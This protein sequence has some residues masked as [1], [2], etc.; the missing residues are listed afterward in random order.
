MKIE[1]LNTSKQPQYEAFA[2]A[3]PGAL[4][5]HSL[6]FRDFLEE[7]LGCASHYLL[8]LEDNEILGVLPLMKTPGPLG[9]VW[10]SLPFY[11]SNGGLLA[12]SAEAAQSLIAAYNEVVSAPQVAS[13]TLISSPLCPDPHKGLRHNCTDTRTG[14][15]TVLS[16]EDH[17]EDFLL[18]R[19][20]SSARRNV[21]KA[22]AADI[23]V[24]VDNTAT[25][26]LASAHF[27]HMQEIGGLA[28]P[29]KF[30]DIFPKHFEAEKDYNIYV[31]R[32]QGKPIAALLLFYSG[33]TVEYYTPVSLTEHRNLQPLSA[34]LAKAMTAAAASGYQY[35]NWGGTWESQEPLYRFKTKW[36]ASDYPYTYYVQVNNAKL[37]KQSPGTLQKAYPGFYV[38]PYSE[39]YQGAAPHEPKKVFS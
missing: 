10:N 16:P 9:E 14:Q 34:I 21:R 25:G 32:L 29:R 17:S 33:T 18:A 24:I 12:Q 19:I 7:L 39:L 15:I 11:G 27:S 37:R 6:K 31:A 28:K 3:Y 2:R 36:A 30:F 13:S 23:E 4:L 8:A 20:A 22:Q 5:Y 35:W 26:F 38:L 1:V